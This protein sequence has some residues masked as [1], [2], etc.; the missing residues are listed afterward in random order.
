MVP[1]VTTT[2]PVDTPAG[3]ETTIVLSVHETGTAAMPLNI[4]ELESSTDPN[5]LPL[6]VI[7][8]PGSPVAG[9]K[10]L[11]VGTPST[12]N[13]I[14]LLEGC[15]ETLTATA[16]EVAPLGT[17]TTMLASDQLITEATTPSKVTLLCPCV[18][19]KRI[20]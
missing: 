18:S 8:S 11:I 9:D 1:T 14:V 5:P 2:G 13:W 6:I 12:A 19:P 4:S 17:T 15:P 10:P 7:K 20:P 16:P 3:T